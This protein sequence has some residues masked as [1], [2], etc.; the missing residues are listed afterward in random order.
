MTVDE[1]A[2]RILLVDDHKTMLWGL[3]R[4]IESNRGR[5]TVVGTASDCPSALAQAERLGPDVIVLDLDLG[6]TCSS[7]VLPAMLAS[8]V[9]RAL[10]LTGTNDPAR[11]DYAV[12]HGARG[13]ISKEA[14]AELVLTA[15][16]KVHQ[17]ELWLERAMLNRVFNEFLSPK[18]KPEPAAAADKTALL[19]AKERQI[20]DMIAEGGGAL[21]KALAQRIFI[22]ENTLRNHL[23]SIYQ[24]L[25]VRNRLELYVYAT[26]HPRLAKNAP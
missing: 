21:N 20:F 12:L 22:S 7:V 19:T 4:L 18:R 24:K 25:D 9:S 10:I 26:R 23:T 1:Q 15:I 2:I 5:M 11:L 14:T 16:E 6:G 13:V 17:G 3:E 8:G